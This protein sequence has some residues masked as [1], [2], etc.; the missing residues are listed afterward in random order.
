MRGASGPSTSSAQ[1]SP[2]LISPPRDASLQADQHDVTQEQ[3]G[4]EEQLPGRQRSNRRRH[5]ETLLP[6]LSASPSLSISAPMHQSPVPQ[7]APAASQAA[8]HTPVQA[9][10]LAGVGAGQLAVSDT[11]SDT[12]ADV[13]SGSSGAQDAANE[14]RKRQRKFRE[15]FA[16]Y[17][18]P[19]LLGRH[20]AQTPALVRL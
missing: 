9:S 19:P 3:A 1:A 16:A 17:T 11:V 20:A 18:A 10:T 12:S 8:L 5:S 2:G 15:G 13:A 7:P 4:H 6:G 14:E